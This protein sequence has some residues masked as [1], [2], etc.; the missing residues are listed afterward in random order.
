M[1]TK[2]SITANYNPLF[3]SEAQLIIIVEDVVFCQRNSGVRRIVLVYRFAYVEFADK[4]S[5][6]TAVALDESLFKGRQ[7]KVCMCI[8]IQFVMHAHYKCLSYYSHDSVVRLFT[9]LHC[10]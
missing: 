8:P 3:I 7:L 1:D 6:K 4:D 10:I 9:M 5:A 2:L